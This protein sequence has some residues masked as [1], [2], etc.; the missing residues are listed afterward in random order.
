[1]LATNIFTA[2]VINDPDIHI[3]II[4]IMFI[5]SKSRTIIEQTLVHVCNAMGSSHVCMLCM[6]AFVGWF[7]IHTYYI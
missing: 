3:I 4:I 1:M 6:F 7:K 5:A 2:A